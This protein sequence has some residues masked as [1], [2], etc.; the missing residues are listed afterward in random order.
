MPSI[1]LSY[2]LGTTVISIIETYRLYISI[3]IRIFHIRYSF[4]TLKYE[5]QNWLLKTLTTSQNLHDVDTSKRAIMLCLPTIPIVHAVV[6]CLLIGGLKRIVRGKQVT[7]TIRIL[8]DVSYRR[9]FNW[10]QHAVAIASML[11]KPY[12]GQRCHILNV[13]D[14]FWW[15]HPCV[16]GVT[17]QC[18]VMKTGEGGMPDVRKRVV[19]ATQRFGEIRHTS[20]WRHGGIS[21]YTWTE[22][23][24]CIQPVRHVCICSILEYPTP[25]GNVWEC[26][27]STYMHTAAAAALNGTSSRMAQLYV[28]V[29]WK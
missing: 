17:I 28:C 20:T 27:M 24:A 8:R 12:L 29:R 9:I 1:S 7:P 14:V 10:G 18:I 6:S 11:L 22:G 19:M 16:R 23:C 13:V 21:T 15:L 26:R 25:W 2:Y 5:L 4:W 3:K